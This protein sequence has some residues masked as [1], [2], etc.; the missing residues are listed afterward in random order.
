VGLFT[1]LLLLPLAPVRGTIWIAEILAEEAER[2]L[3][4]AES[5]ER[6]LAELEAAHLA[7]ELTDEEFAEA[8]AELIDLTIILRAHQEGR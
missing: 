8:Q 6:G 5:P 3:E 1:G 4:M 2:E 7:G